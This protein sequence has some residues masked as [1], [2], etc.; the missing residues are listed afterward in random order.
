LESSKLHFIFAILSKNK[1]EKSRKHNK[2][3]LPLGAHQV[4]L[5]KNYQIGWFEKGS[6]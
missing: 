3:I 1:A 6:K 5:L 2:A 4:Q